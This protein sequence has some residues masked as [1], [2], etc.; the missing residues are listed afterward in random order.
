MLPFGL[1]F[2]LAGSGIGLDIVSPTA[3]VGC[4][5]ERVVKALVCLLLPAWKQ[6]QL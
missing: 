6:I 2:K 4:V 1:A 5:V 3:D